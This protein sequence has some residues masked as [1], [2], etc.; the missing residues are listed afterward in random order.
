MAAMSNDGAAGG[1]VL[2]SKRCV[3]VMCVALAFLLT[4]S[5]QGATVT[6]SLLLD[7]DGTPNCRCR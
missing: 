2:I 5:A 1:L 3:G 7:W 6:F 4:A